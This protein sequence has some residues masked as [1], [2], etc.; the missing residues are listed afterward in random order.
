MATFNNMDLNLLRVFQAIADER[1]LTQA[2]NRLHLSQP[3]VSYALGRL[4][5][6]F[7]DPLFIRTKEGMQPTPTAVELAKPISRALRAVQDALRYAERFDPAE[8]T[9]V[10]RA[11]MTDIAAMVFLPPVCEKL[12]GL[13]PLTRLHVEQ[14]APAQIE[15]A[16]RTGRLD[17]AIGSL[18]ALKPLTH[19]EL[20]FRESYVCM[21]RKR[22]GLPRGQQISLEQFL[23]M[24]HVLVQSAESSHEQVE[25]SFRALGI[26]R[27]IGLDIPHFSV[28]P[29]ILARSD[30]AATLPLRIAKLF[31]SEGHGQFMLYSLPVDIPVVDITFHWHPDFDSDA[32]NIWIRRLIIDL[33]QQYGLSS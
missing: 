12:N 27:K 13:A 8:S 9:R 1:S 2:G 3:A 31:Q 33:L 30:L 29:R 32:G 23:E 7:D 14:V 26:H 16:L 6:I 11:S 25:N 24:S 10:F 20:L 4:R 21:T 15:E 22:K 18:P 5:L 28:L 17:F 19:Y